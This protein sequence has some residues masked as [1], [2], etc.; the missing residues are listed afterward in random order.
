MLY[1]AVSK[2]FG[3]TQKTR[4]K[5]T[6]EQE[7]TL[8]Q[9]CGKVSYKELAKMT[10]K[11]FSAI[12]NRAYKL[13]IWSRKWKK[14]EDALLKVLWGKATQRHIM[15]QINRPWTGIRQRA[16]HLKLDKGYNPVLKFVEPIKLLTGEEKAYIAGFL[17]G[18]GTVILALA[19]KTPRC[20]ERF[21][22][23]VKFSNTSKEALLWIQK[24]VGG[25]IEVCKWKRKKAWKKQ[26]QL[27]MAATMQVYNVLSALLPYL[28][29][30]KQSAAFVLE[31]CKARMVGRNAFSGKEQEI[32]QR[33]RAF[34]DSQKDPTKIRAKWRLN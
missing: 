13:K 12:K 28:I 5:W 25:K 3:M 34:V 19:S 29:V 7:A 21:T 16:Y 23:I 4:T 15:E 2:S 33:Y 6:P 10:G 22:P 18:E 20:R 31:Y 30:K 9:L 11:T 1:T 26:Y 17:D 24:R 27:S 14:E 32:W 8:R